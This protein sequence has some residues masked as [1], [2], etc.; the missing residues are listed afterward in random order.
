MTQTL[1]TLSSEQLAALALCD[2]V[3]VSVTKLEGRQR[4]IEA[5][6]DLQHPPELVWRLLAD[7][8]NLCTFIPNL[9]KSCRIDHPEGGI[10]LEQ[11]GAQNMK[12]VT[13]TARVVLDMTEEFPTA[14]HFRMVEGDF[15]AFS[16]CW[17]CEPIEDRG[18]PGTR[19]TYCLEVWPKATIPVIAIEQR[20]KKDLPA[21]L[22]AI[23]DC[24]DNRMVRN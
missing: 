14:I 10:R 15:K 22:R 2:E 23:R 18:T 20:L 19:L 16:G 13:F 17:L 3:K 1:P 11:V 4:R 21:N 24:L 9:A 5:S 6:I 7:Y 8:E 12:V